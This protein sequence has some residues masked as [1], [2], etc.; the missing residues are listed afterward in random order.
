MDDYV[1]TP[2]LRILHVLTRLCAYHSKLY[3]YPNYQTIREMIEKF[4]GRRISARSLARHLGALERDGWIGRQRRHTTDARG[5]LELHSTLYMLTARA[6][7]LARATASTVWQWS[8]AAAKS[9]MDIALPLVAES[10][11]RESNSN[12]QQRRKPPPKR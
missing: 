10:L 6:C 9:L 5:E 3:C 7:K 1:D 2:D 4:T 12:H 11:T 8:T